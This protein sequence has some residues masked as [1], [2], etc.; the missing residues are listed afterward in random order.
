VRKQALKISNFSAPTLALGVI[1]TT[2]SMVF[3]FAGAAQAAETPKAD[4]V[5]RKELRVCAD[6]A[7]HR[8]RLAALST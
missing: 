6:P 2:V 3:A 1:A 8:Q 7:A 4:L 5:N